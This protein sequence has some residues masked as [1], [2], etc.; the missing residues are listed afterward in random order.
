MS[1]ASMNS[2]C[3]L[4]TTAWRTYSSV[5][6]LAVDGSGRSRGQDALVYRNWRYTKIH[7]QNSLCVYNYTRQSFE[8]RIPDE[9][10]NFDSDA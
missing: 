5:A 3:R 8:L 4:A 10:S 7:T 9:L 6:P 1:W 2:A